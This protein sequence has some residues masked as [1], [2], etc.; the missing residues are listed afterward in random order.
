MK[1]TILMACGFTA[2][3]LG[4]AGVVLPILPTTPFLLLAAYCFA[5]S[6]ERFHRWLLCNPVFGDY[7]RGYLEGLGVSLRAKIVV[8]T[9]LWIAILVSAFAFVDVWWMRVVLLLIAA[10]VTVHVILIRPK[11]RACGEESLK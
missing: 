2:V 9:L 6:S 10:A 4:A 7:I 3:G 8:I 1:R 11:A 5:R